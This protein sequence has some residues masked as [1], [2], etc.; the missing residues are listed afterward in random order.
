MN[1]QVRLNVCICAL[2]LL[3]SI[4]TAFGQNKVTNGSFETT[5]NLCPGPVW[6]GS[7]A[8][9][10]PNWGGINIQFPSL[11]YNNG[12]V[13]QSSSPCSMSAFS[14]PSLSAYAGNNAINLTLH[15]DPSSYSG[16]KAYQNLSDALTTG[17]YDVAVALAG[18][19]T[20]G[21]SQVYNNIFEVVLKNSSSSVP[22]MIVGTFVQ[23]PTAGWNVFTSSFSI[24]SSLSG[25]YDMVE[26]RHKEDPSAATLEDHAV[27]IDDLSI[28]PCQADPCNSDFKFSTSIVGT[29]VIGDIFLTNY[30]A[31]STYLYDWG[32]GYTTSF[33]VS[34]IY[35]VAGTYQVCVTETT[36]DGHRCRTCITICVVDPN[37][38][39]LDYA[40]KMAQPTGVPIIAPNS[41]IEMYPNPTADK[42]DV[43]FNLDVKGQ[44]KLTI[45]DL[46]G[47]VVYETPAQ[48]YEKGSQRI[49]IATDKMPNGIYSVILSMGDNVMTSKLSVSK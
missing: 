43:I 34:H 26:L 23:S 20:T 11:T 2:V 35:S 14:P 8:S 25:S 4:R 21:W 5:A 28:T 15:D 7:Y 47:K 38:I 32:D 6:L 22:E 3:A 33:P 46:Q 12:H 17:C 44:V 16:S 41:T 42:T 48:Y 29:K 36:S 19:N 27:N 45:M 31:G 24:P 49:T 9:V 18:A 1:K 39:S 30:H 13:V 40:H 37:P 10:V